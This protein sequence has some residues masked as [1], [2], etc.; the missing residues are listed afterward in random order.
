[1]RQAVAAFAMS[2]WLGAQYPGTWERVTAP[3]A[4]RR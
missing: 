4:P 2:V 1:L 3:K